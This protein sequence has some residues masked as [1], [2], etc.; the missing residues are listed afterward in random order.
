MAHCSISISTICQRLAGLSST[1]T[2]LNG[3]HAVIHKLLRF[4]TLETSPDI[5]RAVIFI[6]TDCH[7][8]FVYPVDVSARF[9]FDTSPVC[10]H[11]LFF[12]GIQ[13]ADTA[14]CI[15][16]QVKLLATAQS[17]IL[18]DSEGSRRL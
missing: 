3:E 13:F 17:L 10:L 18:Q 11:F 7:L 5:A 8:L 15:S 12:M 16:C 4:Y 9:V 2:G 6:T 1:E 14:I